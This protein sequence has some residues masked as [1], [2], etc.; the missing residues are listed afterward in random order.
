MSFILSLVSKLGFAGII[1]VSS[2]LRL[3]EGS[4][5]RAVTLGSGALGSPKD[6]VESPKYQPGKPVGF[7]Q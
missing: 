3:D 6:L 2:H 4:S 1:A 7:K 5:S